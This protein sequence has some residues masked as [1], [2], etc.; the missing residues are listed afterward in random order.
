MPPRDFINIAHRGASAYT[1]ENTFAAFDKALA[2]GVDNV[3]FDVHF[4]ADGHIVVIHDDTL[5]RTTNGSGP[6]TAQTLDRLRSLDAGEWFS[7]EFKGQSI[8][9]LAHLLERYKGW[10]HF[11]IEIKGRGAGLAKRT[12]DLVRGF[13][14]GSVST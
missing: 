13:G 5:D 4:S 11:H 1:P 9:T 12:A 7:A 10:L 8:P 2:L 14:L 6:V 3:E